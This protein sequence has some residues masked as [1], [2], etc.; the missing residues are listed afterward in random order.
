MQLDGILLFEVYNLF[1]DTI[2]YNCEY[3][4]KLYI[5]IY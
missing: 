1:L 4:N 2:V 5:Y 3:E